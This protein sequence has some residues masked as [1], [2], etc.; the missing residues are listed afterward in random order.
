AH[1]S[2]IRLPGRAWR[3]ATS[4]Q[5]T[6]PNARVRERTQTRRTPRS[7]FGAVGAFPFHRRSLLSRTGRRRPQSYARATVVSTSVKPLVVYRPRRSDARTENQSSK[8]IE[9]IVP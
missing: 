5:R 2:R 7:T 9:K 1:A 6:Q 4:R 8:I 3:D